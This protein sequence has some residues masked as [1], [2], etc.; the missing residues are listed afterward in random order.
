VSLVIGELDA[1]LTELL[2]EDIVL[3][4]EVFDHVLLSPVHEAGEHQEQKVEGNLG[5]HGVQES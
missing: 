1:L 2:A 5:F 4:S 3:G